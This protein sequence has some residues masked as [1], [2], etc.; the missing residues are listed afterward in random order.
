MTTARKKPK[1]RPGVEI[2]LDKRRTLKLDLN[3][4]VSFEE[5]TGINPFSGDFSPSHMAPRQIRAMLWACLRY[6]DEELTEEQVGAWIALNNMADVAQKL[7]EVFE[8]AMPSG[9]EEDDKK[10]PLVAKGS[11]G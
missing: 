11:D 2:V 4:M 1:V 7:L 10:D 9:G 6:E 3:A 8:V 5:A